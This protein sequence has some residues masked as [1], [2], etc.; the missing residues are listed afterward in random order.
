MPTVTTS[1]IEN[2]APFRVTSAESWILCCPEAAMMCQSA[3]RPTGSVKTTA[4]TFPVVTV[5]AR[6]PPSENRILFL[7][8]YKATKNKLVVQWDA[9]GR[10]RNYR[11]YRKCYLGRRRLLPDTAVPQRPRPCSNDPGTHT[12]AGVDMACSICGRR[13]HNRRACP[14]RGDRV[15]IPKAD[16]SDECECCGLGGFSIERHHTRGRS[17]PTHYLDVC[18]ECH[19]K[20]GHGGSFS[21]VPIKPEICRLTSAR[22]VWRD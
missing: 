8:W 11:D 6:S 16:L 14:T 17:D 19:L 5:V 20:C 10:Y 22:T 3:Q 21:N 2:V 1:L 18:R 9:G 4:W 7:D 13:N 12:S 15:G